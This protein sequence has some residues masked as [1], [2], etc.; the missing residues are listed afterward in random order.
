MPFPLIPLAILAAAAGAVG[1]GKAVSAS[2]D[3]SRAKEINKEATGIVEDAGRRM[4]AQV[5]Q[6]KSAL[7][8]LGRLKHDVC[9]TEVAVQ[10]RLHQARQPA[11]PEG[12]LRLSGHTALPW[13]LQ[14]PQ[15]EQ[16][17]AR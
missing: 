10:P 9:E 12:R 11:L 4:K 6:T 14:Q 7:E 5:E 16:L 1:V 3:N 13:L 17:S 2:K 8:K 15:P